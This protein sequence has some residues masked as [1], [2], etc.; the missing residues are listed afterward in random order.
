MAELRVLFLALNPSKSLIFICQR[1]LSQY[2]AN[3][4]KKLR[5]MVTKASNDF[6]FAL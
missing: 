1:K 6:Y 3:D 2:Q 4:A 5:T